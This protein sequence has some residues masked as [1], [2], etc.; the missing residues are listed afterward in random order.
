MRDV[1]ITAGGDVDFQVID[2]RDDKS[3]EHRPGWVIFGILGLLVLIGTGL[4]KYVLLVVAMAAVIAI[5]VWL[6]LI[7]Y[8]AV[9]R[10]RQA[11]REIAA[12]ADQ[13]HM[14][15][16]EGDPRGIYGGSPPAC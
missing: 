1:H 10:R 5:A 14:W 4:L 12:R 11:V 16:M 13:Q 6:S 8:R 3:W 15:V 9:I 7:A 2:Y